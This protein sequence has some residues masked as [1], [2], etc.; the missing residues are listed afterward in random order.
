MIKA[1]KLVTDNLVSINGDMNSVWKGSAST[2]LCS[3]LD[4]STD[5]MNTAI[6]QIAI[7]NTALSL[8]EIYQEKVSQIKDYEALIAYEEANPSLKTT[9]ELLENGKTFSITVYVVNQA[10]IDSYKACIAQLEKEIEEL[11]EKDAPSKPLRKSLAI[12]CQN[13]AAIP[14]L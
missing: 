4:S 2:E 9:E 7:Y 6:G 1:D 10:L 3:S 11:I 13:P 14:F 5:D 8:L 12:P